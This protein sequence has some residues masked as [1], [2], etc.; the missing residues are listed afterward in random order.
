MIT[1]LSDNREFVTVFRDDRAP[2][3]FTVEE[4]VA[5]YGEEALPKPSSEIDQPE[6]EPEVSKDFSAMTCYYKAFRKLLEACGKYA[7][8]DKTEKNDADGVYPVQQIVYQTFGHCAAAKLATEVNRRDSMQKVC[9]ENLDHWSRK[10]GYKPMS[11]KDKKVLLKH[12]YGADFRKR[13]YY[14]IDKYYK[15]GELYSP[16]DL[17]IEVLK[18]LQKKP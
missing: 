15:R 17:V 1:V 4:F 12:L 16:R 10:V 18:S 13:M 3:E 5:C 11:E 6:K 2:E 8:A 9:V 7:W 14:R